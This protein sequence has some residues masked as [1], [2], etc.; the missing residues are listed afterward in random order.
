MGLQN[1]VD[2]DVVVLG[3]PYDGSISHDPGA[4]GAPAV[5]RALAA[6]SPSWTET[7]RSFAG[8][9]INDA[10]DVPVLQ[11]DD[12]IAPLDAKQP[13]HKVRTLR[14][15]KAGRHILIAMFWKMK[16]DRKPLKA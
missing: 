3:I 1:T 12:E 13:C 15:S 11:E 16:P 14:S 7:G 6:D 2:P 4:A 9:R 10:G 8:L 5:L